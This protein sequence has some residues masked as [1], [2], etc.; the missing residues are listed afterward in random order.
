[1]TAAH[2]PE[3]RLLTVCGEMDLDICPQVEEVT[4]V[5]PVGNKTL[6]LDL[7]GCRSSTPWA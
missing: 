5:L 7:P 6:H 2:H 1:M 3:G 4:T